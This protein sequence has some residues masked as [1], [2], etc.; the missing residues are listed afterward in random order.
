MS[1]CPHRI[2][3]RTIILSFL[4]FLSL[5]LYL[6]LSFST[7]PHTMIGCLFFVCLAVLCASA[8]LAIDLDSVNEL[9]FT[10]GQYAASV[11]HP[12][13]LMPQLLCVGGFCDESPSR[14]I[15]R[16][17]ED[18]NYHWKCHPNNEDRIRLGY[19]LVQCEQYPFDNSTTVLEQSCYL[20]FT[21]YHHNLGSDPGEAWMWFALLV[22]CVV[23]VVRILDDITNTPDSW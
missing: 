2:T 4:S 10:K 6:S 7:T 12:D 1:S 5:S 23:G 22:V 14:V 13:R 21:V 20:Q 19:T 15:C 18:R 9:T 11:N 3:I 16:T 17:G 8:P